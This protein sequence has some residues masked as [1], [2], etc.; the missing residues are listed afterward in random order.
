MSTDII[1]GELV[2]YLNDELPPERREEIRKLLDSSPERAREFEELKQTREAVKGLRLRQA[3]TDFNAQVQKRI[4][5]KI[6]E[7][8]ARGSQRFRTARERVD[9]AREGLSR[10][11]IRRRGRKAL[12]LYAIAL[13]VTLPLV[14]AGLAG[15]YYVYSNL[16]QE[17]QVNEKRRAARLRE[18][19]RHERREARAASTLLKVG[20]G[21]LIREPRFFAAGSS[22]H[23]V[24]HRGQEPRERCVFVY[25]P[26]QWRDYLAK[27]R[28][29][30]G[31]RGYQ[32][33][34]EAA[35][36]AIELRVGEDGLALPPEV[37][38]DFL[39]SADRLVA[40][41]LVGRTELWNVSD[42]E[43]YLTVSVRLHSG[44]PPRRIRWVQD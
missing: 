23:L 3:S 41:S 2:D 17:R 43:E 9:A 22:Y 20:A 4:S 15:A 7:L 33:L 24:M 19:A 42:L 35:R 14:A 12:G 34:A 13:I 28:E 8:R 39:G 36:S 29:R 1:S 10:E 30:R 40:L 6:E 44:K 31:L 32:A 26:G 11:E 38:R 27:V 18:L 21:A 16:A 25:D 5:L 37:H